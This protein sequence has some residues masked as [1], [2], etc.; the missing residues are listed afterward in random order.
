MVPCGG[1]AGA[2][3]G[4]PRAARSTRPSLTA[5]HST[6][7]RS[8]RQARYSSAHP[9]AMAGR[10][11]V[12]AA[13]NTRCCDAQRPPAL[14]RENPCG[15][16]HPHHRRGRVAH[17][18]SLCRTTRPF[19]ACRVTVSRFAG[20]WGK[21]PRRP[22]HERAA[23]AQGQ[24]G[25]DTALDVS[26]F[27]AHALLP[28]RGIARPGYGAAVSGAVAGCS[29][30]RVRAAPMAVA[31]KATAPA[32]HRSRRR[33]R[34]RSR[35]SPAL[36]SPA[37]SS[38]KARSAVMGTALSWLIACVRVLTADTFVSLQRASGG[39]RGR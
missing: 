39:G 25:A 30:R 10:R 3:S 7:S 18:R 36:P 23:S 8:S 9:A 16:K 26:P 21:S 22:Q 31:A 1:V 19:T 15:R 14:P 33:T 6:R 13:P 37:S 32:P 28:A 27:N 35:K 34:Q 17:R 38:R 29:A 24:A 11:S 2:G 12:D 20:G 5:H 4:V